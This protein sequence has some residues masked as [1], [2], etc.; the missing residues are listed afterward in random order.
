[1]KA[2][3]A[4]Q[5]GGIEYLKII[6]KEKP[7]PSEGEVLVK[8]KA[9][10]VNPV[11]WKILAGGR[12]GSIPAV[13]PYIVGWDMSGTVEERGHAARR[14]DISDKVYGYIR[15]PEWLCCMNIL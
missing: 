3:V 7:F 10:S 12:S 4:T 15:R 11:D 14:Y 1:M 6:E 13:F 8:I 2:L 5:Y 9:A